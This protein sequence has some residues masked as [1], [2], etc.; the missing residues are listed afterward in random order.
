VLDGE[1]VALDAD[2]KRDF[3]L[4]CEFVLQRRASISLTFMIVDVLWVAAASVAAQPY[5][6]RRRILEELELD[7][8]AWRTPTVL[9]TGTRSGRRCASTSSRASSRS[10]GSKRPRDVPTR[11]GGAGRALC[12]LCFELPARSL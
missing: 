5:R 6:E 10:D 3:A 9:T 1:L 4:L 7:A 11:G 2:G 8:Q 12:L